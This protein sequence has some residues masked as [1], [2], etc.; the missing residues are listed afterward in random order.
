MTPSRGRRSRSGSAPRRA[1]VSLALLA[2]LVPASAATADPVV[3]DDATA[4]PA[5]C[6]GVPLIGPRPSLEDPRMWVDGCGGDFF[7]EAPTEPGI[8]ARIPGRIS[9]RRSSAVR[10]RHTLALE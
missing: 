5:V 1:V 10:L 3:G 7:V 8:A 9:A 4:G 2:A 6:T